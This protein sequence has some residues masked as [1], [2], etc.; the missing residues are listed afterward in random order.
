MISNSIAKR[1]K[2]T[3]QMHKNVLYSIKEKP[4]KTDYDL[5]LN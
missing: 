1:N 5:F 2:P 4:I 3:K